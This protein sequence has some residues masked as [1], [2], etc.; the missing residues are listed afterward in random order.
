[1]VERPTPETGAVERAGGSRRA[2]GLFTTVDGGSSGGLRNSAKARS[3]AGA[4]A[5]A[6][7]AIGAGR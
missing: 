6:L 3:A 7:W 2:G 4:E 1:M 5:L